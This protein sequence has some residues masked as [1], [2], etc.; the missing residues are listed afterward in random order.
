MKALAAAEE[1]IAQGAI[2]WPEQ[3]Y[4]GKLKERIRA[5]EK[6]SEDDLFSTC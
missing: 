4:S 2:W 5:A 1:K 6:V 3:L